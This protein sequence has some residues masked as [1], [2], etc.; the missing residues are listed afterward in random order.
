MYKKNA[1]L[2]IDES[3]LSRRLD[4]SNFI[5]ENQIVKHKSTYIYMVGKMVS[6]TN[7]ITKNAHLHYLIYLCLKCK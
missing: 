4:E 7:N 3:N 5:F 2:Y 6:S 1:F